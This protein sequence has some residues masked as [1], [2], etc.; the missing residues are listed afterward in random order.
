MNTKAR[1]LL[2]TTWSTGTKTKREKPK[3]KSHT[4]KIKIPNFSVINNGIT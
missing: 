1:K 3:R 4:L 2:V